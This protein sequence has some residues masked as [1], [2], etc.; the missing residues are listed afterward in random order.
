[1]K[2]LKTIFII[3]ICLLLTSCQRSCQ[4][5]DRDFQTTAKNY[6]LKQYS[7]GKLI[8]EKKFKGIVNSSTNSDGYYFT[9][10]DTTYE[11]SGD[12]QIFY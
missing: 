7:G 8:F 5:L 1:M 11:I 3:T 9:V 12:I 6:H 10:N 4:K 2:Y